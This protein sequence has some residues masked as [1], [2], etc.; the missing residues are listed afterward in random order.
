LT[1]TAA[2][3]LPERRHARP[4][5]SVSQA[6]GSSTRADI[7]EHLRSD[8]PGTV[9]DVAAVFDLHPNV[10]RTHLELLAD[11]GL[12]SVGRRKHPGGGRPA[13]VYTARD[14]PV[15]PAPPAPA[16][17]DPAVPLLIRLLVALAEERPVA[18]PASR[19]GTSGVQ[20]V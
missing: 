2:P 10:A 11:A 13:K 15:A 5:V 9:R 8:G 20:T 16:Q 7:Y 18:A 12:V 3:V 19:T 6:L 4:G 17:V 1:K 14:E